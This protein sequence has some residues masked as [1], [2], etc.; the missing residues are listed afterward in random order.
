MALFGP[1]IGANVHAQGAQL[2][3]QRIAEVR[4]LEESSQPA[5]PQTPTLAL[6]AGD[7]F[8]FA[9]ERESL[10]TLY[11]TGDYA[12]IRVTAAQQADGLH[13]DFIAVRNF[14]NNVVRID[15][16][17]EPPT[18]PAAQA[19]V[20]LTLGQPFRQ[21]SLNE[22]L[23]RLQSLLHDEGLYRATVSYDLH[24]NPETRQMDVNINV[25]PGVRAHIGAITVKNGTRY[26]DAE[27]LRRSKLTGKKGRV[28]LTSARLTQARDKL[29]TYLVDQGYLGASSLV[30]T[31]SFDPASNTVPLA[32]DV[33]AG[34]RITIEVNGAHL[35][36]SAKRR[37]LPIYA[38]GAVDEDLLQE[39]RRNIRDY[40][41]RQGY[42][43]ADVEVNSQQT[44]GKGEQTIVYNI[45]RGDRYKLLGISFDGN[46]YF[47]SSLLAGR[48]QLQQASFAS[49]GRYSQ[50]LMRDDADSI[51][52][53][54]LSNGFLQ[55]QVTP[56]VQNAS[57]GKKNDLLVEFHIVEGKQ[58]TISQLRIEG[59]TSVPTQDLLAIVGSTE[60]Q[61][62]SE[63]GVAS[64]RN[65]IL[66]YYY[67]NGF[68]DASFDEQ[69]TNSGPDKVGLTYHIT[70]GQRIEVSRVLLTGY[71]H[72]R[73]GIIS[74]QVE[75]HA[76]G[77]LR[78]GD[79]LDS[80]RQLYNL[81][82]FN[83]VQIAPQNPDGTDPDKA[84]VVD[85]REG[86][87]YTIGYG[88][89]FEVQRIAGGSQNPSGTILQ[90]SPRGIF[91][92]ARN[93]MFGRA[94]TLSFTGR[95]STLEYRATANYSAP[96]F[97]T[98]RTLTL[99]L[100]GYADKSQDVNTFTSTRLQGG[101]ALVE[102]SSPSSSFVYQ[103]YYRRVEASDINQ[104]INREQ[105]PL[106]SQPTLVSGVG[107]TYARDRRDNPA[108]ATKGNF[109]TIDVT[110]TF[111]AIGSG[112]D[113]FRLSF[114]NSSFYPFGRAF[115]FARSM[116]FGY[117][118][119]WDNTVE[120]D[121]PSCTAS[122]SGNASTPPCE[123]IPLPERFFAGGGASLRGFSLNQAGPRD[124]VTGFPVGGLAML[125]FNQELRF[126]MKLPFIGNRLGG[127]LFYD[128][129][130]VFSDIHHITLRWKSPSTTDLNYFSH[131]V[132]FGVRYPTPIGPVRVDFGYQVNPA[133]YSVTTTVN[134]LPQTTVHELPHFGFFFNIGSIF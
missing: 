100:T 49:Y 105:I 8:R 37:L 126:P 109:N 59:N 121:D 40:F 67:N 20:R 35:S 44:N 114:Q 38:E 2:E 22:G 48:L 32:L 9:T 94:Q 11:A 51:R 18:E 131:T 1:L 4:V 90:A 95:A 96:N 60:G 72:T 116:R 28:D 57:K 26:S 73:P 23:A 58:T 83:R 101:L 99:Q 98:K 39:G 12:N 91:Q 112:A 75:V 106:Y 31:G 76:D 6:K 81:G 82:I 84:V 125:T 46:R 70:E 27:I 13:I 93:N 47:N 53:L 124:P 43:D 92:I 24:P 123:T 87:R 56:E 36:K 54:Y 104:T 102:K 68:P 118:Q 110:N 15:G 128:G 129:G 120:P 61:P 127:T 74:R 30:T 64:D 55:A 14:Y 10:R 21:A 80:E 71:Q 29:R 79:V 97:M 77:P 45:N 103:I 115:V 117:E 107:I 16:L 63:A 119:P 65:N 130:N 134:G 113:F 52:S 5:S 25:V 34:P 17:K 3:G 132:G 108:D 42:F 50:Q 69:L 122:S 85:A 133:Q 86:N 7:A 88:G 89:G 111:K 66:A 41:Q 19:A 62:F 78:E 33:T